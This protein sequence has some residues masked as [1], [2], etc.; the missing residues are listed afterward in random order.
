LKREFS[1]QR[2]TYRAEPGADGKGDPPGAL[3]PVRLR[4]EDLADPPAV[5]TARPRL[6]WAVESEARNQAQT[7]YRI[8]VAGSVE[9]LAADRGTLWDSG[10]VIS[11]ETLAVPYGGRRLRSG[12][13]CHWKVMSWDREGAPSCWSEPGL[14]RVGLLEEADWQA[15]AWVGLGE[16]VEDTDPPTGAELDL[17][18]NAYSASPYLR[19]AFLPG[20]PV[21][22]ATLYATARG[23]YEA[24]L[25]GERVGDHVL[26]PGWTDYRKRIQ[27]QAFDVTGMLVPGENVLGAILGDGWYSGFMGPDPKRRGAHY[28]SRPWFLAQLRLEYEDGSEE[29]VATDASWLSAVGPI[30][31]SDPLMGERYDAR[32]ELVG[33]DAPGYD[34]TS[35]EPVLVEDRVPEARGGPKLVPERSEPVRVTEE[36]TPR[37]VSEPEPGVFVFDMGQNMVGWARLLVEGE[38][39]TEVRMRFAEALSPDGTVYTENL[40]FARQMDAYVLKGGGVEV[41]E[42]RFTFH[43]FRYVEVA[44]YPGTPTPGSLT[45]VVAHSDAGI[46]GSFECSDE[47][48]NKLFRNVLWGQR[49]NF[50]SV[51]TDCPQ[52]DERLGWLADA[53]V[54]AGTACFNMDLRAFFG[55]WMDDVRDAQSA[56]GAF[57]DT[58]PLLPGLEYLAK[59]APAWGDGGVIVPWTLWRRYGDTRPIEEN[60]EA[61][62]RWMEYVRAANPNYLRERRLHNN[63]GDWLSV[64][65]ETPKDV[66]ATAYW[67]YMAKLMAEMA[68]ATG[69]NDEAERYEG[70]FG[71]IKDAFNGAYVLE[72]GRIEGETQTCYALALHVGLLPEETRPLA[73]KSLAEDI[74]RRGHHLTTGFVGVG[75]LLP[76]L[77]DHGYEE[78]AYRLLLQ[79][80]YP[81]WLYSVKNGATTIWE[82]WDGWTEE[83]GFQSP[84]MNS[85]NHYSLGSVGE[86][87]YRYVAGIDADPAAPGFEH[88]LIRPRPG[89]GLRWARAEYGSARGRIA[90]EWELEGST[91]NLRVTVPA[92]AVATVHLPASVIHEVTEGGT[93]VRDA[94]GV[95]VLRAEHGVLVLSLGS[96]DF[97]FRSRVAGPRFARGHDDGSSPA[98]PGG[99]ATGRSP[100]YQRKDGR[101]D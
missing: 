12:Q 23:V 16:D 15:C 33:W 75:I 14:W 74:E 28:G 43:G 93:P 73:A 62:S 20:G 83:G 2:A 65:P 54:F 19:K 42:P 37:A 6:S 5:G 50:L 95:E 96:G 58:A 81:S 47:R 36:L 56:D 79:E 35:W 97:S 66:L 26:S 61:M 85:L 98:D 87:L 1:Q 10:T 11:S 76:V 71:R 94:G 38:R 88:V 101:N 53:Q 4:C 59:G 18:Q 90:S 69:R 70:L 100:T 60:W 77:C 72:G 52:R 68:R 17:L 82:R 34:D 32:R 49:G 13:Q 45:G 99:P 3:R 25:N 64:G 46:T 7:A 9:D 55:K 86:W 31:Y 24:R 39:G 78:L 92:N 63:Y 30:R 89:G 21:R 8:L 29:V 22:R 44:G 27:Y 40:R 51:P 91:F 41:Y 84:N 67:A 48:V 80:S 57:P